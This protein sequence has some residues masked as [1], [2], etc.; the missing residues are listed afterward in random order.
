MR[1]R[2]GKIH[3]EKKEPASLPEAW[4]VR[5]MSQM[6]VQTQ[7]FRKRLLVVANQ[8]GNCVDLLMFKN[9]KFLPVNARVFFLKPRSVSY[10]F[11]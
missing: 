5:E 9:Q 2:G 7:P 3:A 8:N 1:F 4:Q 10:C 11:V 6:Q